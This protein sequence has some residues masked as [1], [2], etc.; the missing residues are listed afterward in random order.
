MLILRSLGEEE[1]FE[2]NSSSAAC[3]RPAKNSPMTY[4]SRLFRFSL[5]L[6]I[7]SSILP[8]VA[9]AAPLN[10]VLIMTDD[11]G[12]GDTGFQGNPI[13][14]TPHLDAMAENSARL[15][16]FM[17]SPVC[18]PTRASLMTGRYSY[19][20]RAIDTF[21]GRALMETEEV[22]IAEVLGE[23][24]YATGLFGK[25]HLGD[26]YPLRPMDQ[27]FDEVLGHLGGGL[28]QPSDHWDNQK[29]YTDAILYH[30]GESIKTEGY[31]TDVYFDAAIDWIKKNQSEGKPSFSYIATNAPHAPWHDVP[32][33]WY[34]YYKKQ[35]ITVE[36]LHLNEGY[37]NHDERKVDAD[38]LAR[39]Y[40]MISNID[41]NVGRLVSALKE[42][43]ML[44][45]TLLIFMTDNGPAPNGFSG[46]LRGKK[47]M[48]Y[49]GGVRSPFYV[50]WPARLSPGEKSAKIAAHIDVF[51]TILEAAG[52]ELPSGLKIDGRSILPLLSSDSA[53]ASWPDRSIVLQ[54]HRG[55]H[56]AAEHNF[57]VRTDRWKLVRPSGFGLEKPAPEAPFELYDLDADPY[58]MNNVASEHPEMV[59]TLRADYQTWF[60]DV[61]STRKNNY[62]PP[63]IQ[64]GS[65]E[66]PLTVLSKQDRRVA[67]EKDPIGFWLIDVAK[68]GPY[69]IDIVMVKA[70]SSGML[71]VTIGEQTQTRPIGQTKPISFN[72]TTGSN[73]IAAK[74]INQSGKAT[75][76]DYVTIKSGNH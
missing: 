37:P 11:Q 20:T 27:G 73:Q 36:S 72:L 7:L 67:I 29:R 38:T 9:T 49:E 53:P 62:A 31:C 60:S 32:E 10:V 59:A 5:C 51:P 8:N 74:I 69:E 66:E 23:N 33:E 1:S 25:W 3:Q 70:P 71:E 52:I 43:H 26:N 6:V 30:N 48:P 58:E 28:G 76:V 50:H 56:P 63:R 4:L 40:A 15:P 61:S 44:D 45:D 16:N 41:D 64:I 68:D 57:C 42:L 14:K 46:G 21:K 19:R 47:T 22:T 34:D 55:N 24:G 54:S 35:S 17:V 39:Y 2:A 18:T 13:L 12:Y 75:G 65:E